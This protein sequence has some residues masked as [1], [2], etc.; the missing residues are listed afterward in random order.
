M[1][2]DWYSGQKVVCVSEPDIT[3]F[4]FIYG[5]KRNQIPIVG[6]KYT[7]YD[8][9]YVG[10]YASVY[11][12]LE[13]LRSEDIVRWNTMHFKPLEEKEMDTLRALLVPIREKELV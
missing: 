4:K 1:S 6:E 3:T 7:V 11:V 8:A 13:E 5:V 12:Q 2:S 9:E 10:A